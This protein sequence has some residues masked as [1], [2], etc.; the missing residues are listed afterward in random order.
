MYRIRFFIIERGF[1]MACSGMV[2][3]WKLSKERQ[4]NVHCCV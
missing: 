2:E 3:R 4:R 1:E